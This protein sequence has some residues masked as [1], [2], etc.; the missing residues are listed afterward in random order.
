MEQF[1]S[2]QW[3]WRL[4]ARMQTRQMNSGA[5]VQRHFRIMHSIIIRRRNMSGTIRKIINKTM[6]QDAEGGNPNHDPKNGQF[7]AGSKVRE[8]RQGSPVETV[9][10]QE[11]NTLHTDKGRLH[12]S[13]AVSVKPASGGSG[14][15]TTTATKAPAGHIDNRA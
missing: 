2:L 5:N 6:A 1:G 10:K 8:N 3:S 4:G 12:V 11:G 15:K 14:G 9:L 13:H 7:A